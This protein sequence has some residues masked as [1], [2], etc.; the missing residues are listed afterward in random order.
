M[1]KELLFSGTPKTRGGLSNER[2]LVAH[3]PVEFQDTNLWVIYASKFLHHPS[4]YRGNWSWQ[5][6][7]AEV[8][9]KQ[10]NCLLGII[11]SLDLEEGPKESVAGW[12]LSEMLTRV[13]VYIPIKYP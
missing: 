7:D 10:Y 12:M 2:E 3:C 5:S 13:P 1:S 9:E 6:E 4:T 11:R 8:Q